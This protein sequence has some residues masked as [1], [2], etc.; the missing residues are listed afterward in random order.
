[1]HSVDLTSNSRKT[2]HMTHLWN[3]TRGGMRL[4]SSSLTGTASS[5]SLSKHQHYFRR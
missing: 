5:M 3:R 2:S 1:M 4:V